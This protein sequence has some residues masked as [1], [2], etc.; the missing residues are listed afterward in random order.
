MQDPIDPELAQKQHF[1][2]PLVFFRLNPLTALVCSD[3]LQSLTNF[4]LRIPGRDYIHFICAY[5]NHLP[6]LELLDISTSGMM[7]AF[8]MEPILAR[9]TKLRHLILDG[10]SLIRLNML[11]IDWRA[12]G[13]ICSL[14]GVKRA[15]ERRKNFE[16]WFAANA[17]R[18]AALNQGQLLASDV[19]STVRDDIRHPR[20]GRRG[21]ATATI[22]LKEPSAKDISLSGL[23][24]SLPANISIPQFRVLPP[25]PSL[26]SL[27]IMLPPQTPDDKR[28]KVRADFEKGWIEGLAQLAV[29][30]LRL[31]RSWQ[32]GIR[33]VRF[34]EEPSIS[35][36]G[37]EGL[38]D[39]GVDGADFLV[40]EDDMR[41]PVLCLVGPGRNADHVDGCGHEVG[42]NVWKDDLPV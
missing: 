13:N 18:S 15:N 31:Y 27:S 5:P 9:F 4:R 11:E 28:A 8:E 17:P 2:Q 10:C 40:S 34:S 32:N 33:V 20:R 19:G 21:L 16:A 42:W 14:A 22:S 36:K 37:L 29:N 12:L 6:I 24:S 3:Y 30:R 23:K 35:E 41:T 1:A 26:T 25:L 39:V 38:V 7:L